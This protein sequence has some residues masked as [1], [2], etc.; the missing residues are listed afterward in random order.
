MRKIKMFP[1]LQ[2]SNVNTIFTEL[3][4]KLLLKHLRGEDTKKARTK[5]KAALILAGGNWAEDK[6][7]LLLPDTSD[8][9]YLATE[10]KQD[11]VEGNGTAGFNHLLEHIVELPQRSRKEFPSWL[12]H[13]VKRAEATKDEEKRQR[14]E[15]AAHHHEAEEQDVERDLFEELSSRVQSQEL[16]LGDQRAA[17]AALA[18]MKHAAAVRRAAELAR[19]SPG[20][21]VA[22]LAALP[23]PP[24][25]QT[26]ELG[27]DLNE[28][29]TKLETLMQMILQ[30]NM[31]QAQVSVDKAKSSLPAAAAA[32][33]GGPPPPGGLPQPPPPSP[34]GLPQPPPPPPAAGTSAGA[35]SP[36]RS[37]TTGKL[38]VASTEE[39]KPLSKEETIQFENLMKD[40]VEKTLYSKFQNN[41][42]RNDEEYLTANKGNNVFGEIALR[43]KFVPKWQR[44]YLARLNNPKNKI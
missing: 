33:Q 43:A 22:A 21:G 30:L 18:T 35:P 27:A 14:A 3:R 9:I 7:E 12:Q 31:A 17:A 25:F 11:V 10:L 39:V 36:P 19:E 13:L 26:G 8:L 23:P 44:A 37:A 2:M 38:K 28:R 32:A 6:A 42:I 41:E 4:R 40:K 24:A 34:G 16:P 5:L 29:L 15:A 1:H 20:V